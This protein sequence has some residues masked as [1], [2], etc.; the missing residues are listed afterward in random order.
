VLA[1]GDPHAVLANPE[2][3]EVYLGSTIGRDD[4]VIEDAT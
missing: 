2:V 1:I 3:I 4:P